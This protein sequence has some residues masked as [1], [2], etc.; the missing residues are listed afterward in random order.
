MYTPFHQ[1]GWLLIT[2]SSHKKTKQNKNK[3]K[4]T[5][6]AKQTKQTNKQKTSLTKNILVKVRFKILKLPGSMSK[7]SQVLGSWSS[8]VRCTSQ[9]Y[10]SHQRQRWTTAKAVS[11]FKRCK[12]TCGRSFL[13]G[14]VELQEHSNTRNSGLLRVLVNRCVRNFHAAIYFRA[15]LF[16]FPSTICQSKEGITGSL[17][18]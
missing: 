11:S 1:Y 15:R 8:P 13:S 16:P 6:K 10:L 7:I 2:P 3:N 14:I 4:K 17:K 9:N 5:N 18:H 12:T